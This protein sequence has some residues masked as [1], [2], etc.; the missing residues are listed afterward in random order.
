MKYFFLLISMLIISLASSAQQTQ[1]AYLQYRTVPAARL[2]L[3]DSS[4]KELKAMLDKK[5][6]LMIVVFSPECDHCKHE[7]EELVRNINKFKNIQIMMI[8]M[9]PLH[10]INDFAN[11]YNL[12]KYKNITV[13][14]DYAYILPVY[15]DIKSLP[16]HA[17]YNKEKQLITAFEGSMTIDKILAQFRLKK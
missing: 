15:Y 3:A 4:G 17:F 16:F 13:G 9:Q 2:L 1:P 6:P 10:Q 11:R 12:V 8:S 14:R 5:K 7:A